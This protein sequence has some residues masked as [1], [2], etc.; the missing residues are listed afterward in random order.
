VVSGLVLPACNPAKT[1]APQGQWIRDHVPAKETAFALFNPDLAHHKRSAFQYYAWPLR[2]VWARE[3]T[4]PAEDAHDRV[5]QTVADVDRFFAQHPDS[6]CLV[7]AQSVGLL[8]GSDR[9]AWQARIVNRDFVA[10]GYHYT[11]FGGPPH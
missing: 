7:E 9:E 4:G 3:G 5:L 11:V 10:G 6:I 2:V 8:L 1:Y